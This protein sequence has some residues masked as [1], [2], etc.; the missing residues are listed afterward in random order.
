MCFDIS[1][2]NLKHNLLAVIFLFVPV[3]GSYVLFH[4]KDTMSKGAFKS[5]SC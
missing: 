1:H 3:I 2:C 4:T 5:T